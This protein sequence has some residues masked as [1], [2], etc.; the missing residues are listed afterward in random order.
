MPT[1]SSRFSGLRRIPKAAFTARHSAIERGA[2]GRAWSTA[3]Y[4]LLK[5]GQKSRWHRVDAAD[6]WH[7][8]AGA[9]LALGIA[10]GAGEAETLCLGSDL[11]GGER[12]QAIVPAGAWQQAESLGA[13]TLVGC[14]VSP[15]FMFSAFEASAGSLDFASPAERS[16]KTGFGDNVLRRWV[17]V[18]PGFSTTHL[19]RFSGASRCFST[20]F[21]HFLGM[22]AGAAC[23]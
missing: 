13:W 9:P 20:M 19:L 6:V 17:L 21:I 5:Q 11:A 18:L 16:S 3:I 2:E 15:G 8:Y 22:S 12:P 4:F 23:R 14:T 1:R 10:T 7:W